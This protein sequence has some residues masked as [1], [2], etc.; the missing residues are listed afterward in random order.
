[1][2]LLIICLCSF[3]IYTLNAQYDCSSPVVISS[4][5]YIANNLTTSTGASFE[6][7]G[8]CSNNY[9]EKDYIFQYSPLV[10]EE[11][12][13]N[14]SINGGVPQAGIYVFTGCAQPPTN[15]IAFKEQALFANGVDNLTFSVVPGT[16]YYIFVGT[17]GSASFNID[18]SKTEII[19][20]AINKSAPTQTLDVNGAIRIGENTTTPYKGTIR[21]NDE[22]GEFEGYN[23]TEWVKLSPKSNYGL[24]RRCGASVIASDGKAGDRFGSSVAIFENYAVVGAPFHDTNGNSNQGKAYIFKYNGVE[25]VEEAILTASDGI[26]DHEF[27]SSVA[28]FGDFALIG[29]PKFATA[30]AG[31]NIGKVY[32]FHKVNGAWVEESTISA[33]DAI[34]D[35]LFGCRISMSGDNVIITADGTTEI[36]KAYI[37]ERS[38]SVWTEVAILEEIGPSFFGACVTSVSMHE[39]YVVIGYQGTVDV[40]KKESNNWNYQTTLSGS[41][42]IFTGGF[43][44]SV[45]IYGDNI[46]VG[47]LTNKSYIYHNDNDTWTEVLELNTGSIVAISAK[48]ALAGPLSDNVT[49]YESQNSSWKSEAKLKNCDAI[50][51][52]FFGQTSAI[53]GRQII[54]GAYDYPTNSQPSR[55]KV[56]FF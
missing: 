34:S 38:G 52:D 14:L 25:W 8:V 31:Q 33:S 4:L 19:G 51:G 9:Q 46:I 36:W 48:I 2:R 18:I 37:Y 21:W 11:L 22:C 6:A 49:L 27:G 24:A 45:S 56:Y 44:N 41:N 26:V 54:I 30:G 1:M 50:A 42:P 28:I 7:S 16:D 40:Y 12:T 20:V 13:I 29:S 17:Q 23:G 39:N 47:D 55:G 32:V 15:C 5:P 43:G 10:E 3:S 53:Y 35:D